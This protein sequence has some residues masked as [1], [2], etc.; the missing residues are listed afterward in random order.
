MVY[1]FGTP[2]SRHTTTR[3]APNFALDT[4]EGGTHT[5]GAGELMRDARVQ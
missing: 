2:S 1:E 4:C 5:V 3:P